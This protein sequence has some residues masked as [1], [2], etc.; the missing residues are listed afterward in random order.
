MKLQGQVALVTGGSRGIG[1]A[2]CRALAADGAAVAINY[3]GSR[4]PAEEL[5]AEIQAAGGRAIA[6]RGDVADP[7]AAEELVRRAVEDLGGIDI[8]VN[9]AGVAHDGLVYT[10]AMDDWL[11][12]M[13]V[14]FGGVFHCT[15]AV[16]PHFM[17]KGAGVIVNVSSVMGERG[18][19]GESNY[20]AS[21][22]AVNAFTR[23]CAMESARFGV[24]VNA[25]LPGFAP[26]DLVAGLTEGATGR[27]IRKQIPLRDFG[28]VQQIAD[29]VRFLC[30]PES[31]YMTGSLVNVDGGAMTALGLG[32]P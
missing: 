5:A 6:V 27:S 12:V 24:R 30:G 29:V 18:W 14:N 1:A 4:G 9:N 23:C 3:R 11:H 10:M 8:L 16:L 21:K 25:V 26:T 2:V 7:A 31:S 22:G 15:K 28:R 32:R 13:K 19:I 20:A 17:S